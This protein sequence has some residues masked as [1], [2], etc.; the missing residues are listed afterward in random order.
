[1]KNRTKLIAWAIVLVTVTAIG[2]S[3]IPPAKAQFVLSGWD[4]DDGYGQGISLVWP[5]ENSTGSW[6][7]IVDPAFVFPDGETTFEVNATSDTA[8]K[9]IISCQINYTLLDLSTFAEARAIMRSN[10]T[11]TLLDET[12]FSQNNLTWDGGSVY[13]DTATTWTFAYEVVINVIIGS[14]EI[15]VVELF[16]EVYW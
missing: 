11:V 9:I 10:I 2:F 5:Y 3:T 1:M 15:Y 14:G 8:I 6:V 13:N 16:Y 4:F 12:V 7:K